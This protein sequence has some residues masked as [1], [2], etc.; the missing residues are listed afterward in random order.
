MHHIGTYIGVP[1]AY[2]VKIQFVYQLFY[3]LTVTFKCLYSVSPK[4]WFYDNA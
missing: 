2:V 1:T 4:G 3:N